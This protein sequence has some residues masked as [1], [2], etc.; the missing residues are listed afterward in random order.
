M[1]TLLQANAAGF[2]QQVTIKKNG[3]SLKSF[4]R[5]IKRQTGYDVIYADKVLNDKK[6]INAA[7][8]NTSLQAALEKALE[9]QT[10]SFVVEDKSIIVSRK[11]NAA[12]NN[13]IPPPPGI[14]IQGKIVDEHNQPLA[15]VNIKAAITGNP[16]HAEWAPLVIT[17]TTASRAD[18]S[19]SVTVSEAARYLIF[20]YVGY[21]TKI[22]EIDNQHFITVA[23]VAGKNALDDIQIVAYGT[24][25]RRMAT[26]SVTSVKSEQL[27][28]QP[29]SNPL[30]ALA[31]RAA[32]VYI[33]EAAGVAG[34]TV[35]LQIRGQNSISAGINPL[36]II[37]GVPYSSAATENSS[38]TYSPTAIV[39]GGLSPFDN[40]PTSDIEAIE[41]LKDADATAIYG[42]RAAN[43]VVVITTK[44]GKS[45]TMKID[46]NVY[47]GISK[48][49]RG[50]HM[51]STEQYLAMRKKAFANDNITPTVANAP[52]LINFGSGETDFLKYIMGNNSHFTD[53][54]VGIS[55]GA[56]NT[57][58]LI[59]SNFRHQSAVVPGS[60]SDNKGTVRFNIQSQSEKNIFSI[61][62]S[63]AYTKNINN[64]PN[65]SVSG[66]YALPPNLPLY[67]AD[68]SFYWDNN[69]TNPAAALKGPMSFTSDNIIANSTLK[70]NIL[71]GLS[72]KTDLGFNRLTVSSVK[73]STRASRNPNTTTTGSVTL[74]TNYT[75][76][77][78]IEPQL[79]YT[80]RIGSG[81]LDVL[82]G[83][84]Y[85]RTKFVEPYFITG[86]F[87]NDLLYNDLSSVTQLLSGSG[88][89]DNKY[90][91][92]FGRITYSLS[93]KYILNF[94][95]RRDGSSR[96][97]PGKR[98]GN[99]GSVGGAWI[100]TEEK[101]ARHH[102]PWISFGK[103]RGSYGTL[104]NDQVGDYAYLSLYS[105]FSLYPSYNGV[106]ALNPV[107]LSNDKFSWEVTKKLELAADVN[108][109]DD[110]I[111][112]TA[113][114]YRNRSTNLLLSVPV[115]TQTGFTS[116]V[117]NLPALVQNTGW[118]FTV[119]SKNIIKGTFSWNTSVNVTIPK[120]KL[121]SYTGLSSS[122]YANSLVIGQPLSVLQAYHFTGFK[123]GIAQFQD[124]DK[125]GAITAGSFTTT[126]KG[127]YGVAGS[128][129][130]KYMGG[131]NN[132]FTYK[133]F[134]LDFLFQFV[135][136]QGYNIYYN[137]SI[138]GR[139]TNVPE[140]VLSKPFTYTT[141]TASPAATAFN[142]YKLSDAA[143]SD[144]SFIRLK[145]VSLSYNIDNA[146][147]RRIGLRN[148]NVYMRGQN[149]FTITKYLG[150]DPE[151]MGTAV[152]PMK[153]M[154]LGLQTSL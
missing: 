147:I 146:F 77:Y 35:S 79:N 86:S 120:N 9:G 13:Y 67:K 70:F 135:K 52:D 121:V 106:S 116:Y 76:V 75:Q 97:G 58:Y 45:G 80:R 15:G 136:K 68:G 133:G 16:A 108:F 94:N 19:F 53:A 87:T 51:L 50:I 95:G 4:F 92:M 36:Y 23:M 22:V 85:Q 33:T 43:G 128:T 150:L 142:L 122:S 109:L 48:I 32:G 47:S 98:F 129:A 10:V 145:T 119:N 123:E 74:Q 125:N 42:S 59:S 132:T 118:E 104:G 78:N 39:G 131:I 5:E 2:A 29:V 25:T 60:Y 71:P 18:G 66:V 127:D 141:L 113:A 64:L 153:L 40:I 27:Q 72:F 143:I 3:I 112:L 91:S 107:R 96:F 154:S 137:T 117:G 101:W 6:T 152:P 90:L 83:G 115:P 7:F 34:S 134:Q 21:D 84:T 8:Q 69:Y 57:Q 100:F 30:Q 20:S 38:G 46:A 11:L 73:A 1:C 17:G 12:Y 49:T 151:T 124:L 55:G 126:G 82:A 37:D 130:P 56:K 89:L 105:S 103:L 114:W 99:F 54:T 144:A 81:K 102:L 63:G 61:N 44:K 14:E 31:G 24:T 26:G 110:R 148:F 111:S 65:A 41:I 140:D 28:K 138:P 93:S 139:S 149:L 88:F 62:L